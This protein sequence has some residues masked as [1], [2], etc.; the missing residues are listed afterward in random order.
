MTHSAVMSSCHLASE[1]AQGWLGCTLEGRESSAGLQ[2]LGLEVRVSLFM[3]FLA[4]WAVLGV[5]AQPFRSL[6]P[7]YMLGDEA[8]ELQSSHESGLCDLEARRAS[9]GAQLRDA[10]HAAKMVWLVATRYYA[11]R[12]WQG[13]GRLLETMSHLECFAAFRG[14]YP[15]GTVQEAATVLPICEAFVREASE[16]FEVDRDMTHAAQQLGRELILSREDLITL[17]HP[18]LET[19]ELSNFHA[20][21]LLRRQAMLPATNLFGTYQGSARDLPSTPALSPFWIPSWSTS[22]LHSF[23][24]C[25]GLQWHQAWEPPELPKEPKWLVNLGAGDGSC[26][27]DISRQDNL[28]R[29]VLGYNDPA[30]CLARQGFRGLCLGRAVLTASASVFSLTFD[31]IQPFW[32]KHPTANRCKSFSLIVLPWKA[33]CYPEG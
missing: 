12:R 15:G 23:Q 10:A 11:P 32:L 13:Y 33:G 17:R 25:E 31:D 28:E 20:H 9:Y 1:W 30:N 6:C 4:P 24:Q 18:C 22:S 7:P 21:D 2:V 26:D 5:S 27:Q 8:V 14:C 16:V 29:G 3:S 19:S